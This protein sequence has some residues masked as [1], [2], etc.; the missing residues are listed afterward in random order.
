LPPWAEGPMDFLAKSRLALE[1]EHVSKSLHNWID[2]ICGYK[3]T[4]EAADNVFY[5]LCY[6]RAVDIESVERIPG[7]KKP[8]SSDQRIWTNSKTVVRS[9]SL[10]QTGHLTDT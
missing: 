5:Y 3:Q 10:T 6:E 7:E 2:L 8:P 4:G 9:S 1:S